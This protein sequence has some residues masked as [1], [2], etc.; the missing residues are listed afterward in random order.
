[1]IWGF[2][3]V[4]NNNTQPLVAG[5]TSWSVKNDTKYKRIRKVNVPE[6]LSQSM[7]IVSQLGQAVRVWIDPIFEPL[8]V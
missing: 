4:I 8:K 5:S 3:D 7:S 1:M 6:Q 2:I